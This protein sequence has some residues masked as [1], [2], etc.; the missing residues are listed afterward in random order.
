MAS[1]LGKAIGISLVMGCAV[2][3]A[4]GASLYIYR[5][6][7]IYFSKTAFKEKDPSVITVVIDKGMRPM[8]IAQRLQDSGVI[9]DANAFYRWLHYVAKEDASLKAGTYELSPTMSPER[10]VEELQSGRVPQLKVTFPEG[11]RK[12]EMA[13]ILAD[14]GIGTKDGNLKVIN[15]PKTVQ[16]FGVPADVPGGIEG[17]LY[18]DTYQFNKGAVVEV[19]LKKMRSRL[20]E[21]IDARMQARMK[22]MGWSLH[23][24]LTLASIVEKETGQPVERP[25]IA[26]LFHARLKQGMKLQTDPTVIYGIPNYDGDIRRRDLERP[27]AYNTYIIPALPPGPIAQPGRAAIEAVLFPDNTDSLYFVARGDSGLHE[28]CPTYACHEAAV[29]K[30]QVEFYRNKKR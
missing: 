24:V 21:V 23:K 18:P 29:Q 8:Q 13:Q 14:A 10:I 26:G 11:L 9:L 4:L 27:H 7:L 20:D 25:R 19:V 15:D 3:M 16:A 30:W 2:A 28:F 12:E 17:Y 1:K 6:Q 22:E 5:N